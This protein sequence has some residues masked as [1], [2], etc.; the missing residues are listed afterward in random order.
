LKARL[1]EKLSRA[2]LTIGEALKKRRKYEQF[3]I[4]EH[5]GEKRKIFYRDIY[6]P[7]TL[8]LLS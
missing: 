2:Y 4:A 3:Y 1:E 8:Q 5:Y 6:Y 7:T